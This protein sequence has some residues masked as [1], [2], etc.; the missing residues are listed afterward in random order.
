MAPA[1][2]WRDRGWE[3]TA[4]GAAIV[5]G[6]LWRDGSLPLRGAAGLVLVAAAAALFFA[7]RTRV[8]LAYALLELFVAAAL[9]WRA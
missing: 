6:T 4:A 5:L 9:A 7:L 8:R 3:L 1:K 2:F